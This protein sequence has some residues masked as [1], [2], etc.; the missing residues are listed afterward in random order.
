MST[1]KDSRM[2]IK[3]P[4]FL[5]K[6]QHYNKSRFY[7]YHIRIL[8]FYDL[9]AE[10]SSSAGCRWDCQR[11]YHSNLIRCNL[12]LLG[13]SLSGVHQNIIK[14]AV[15]RNGFF[16]VWIYPSPFCVL[17]FCLHDFLQICFLHF[18]SL[19]IW[20]RSNMEEE[21]EEIDGSIGTQ[22][23]SREASHSFL[24]TRRHN[25]VKKGFTRANPLEIIHMW[26]VE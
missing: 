17:F 14:K 26:R 16:R 6:S 13:L 21:E 19:T 24:D 5:K 9:E 10:S 15:E 22:S 1:S 3:V 7:R 20:T 2:G 23:F 8:N 4:L 11:Q 25:I 18:F 12:Q